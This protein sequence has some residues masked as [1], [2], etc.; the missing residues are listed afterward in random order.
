MKKFFLLVVFLLALS[1]CCEPA[2]VYSWPL[3]PPREPQ[4][5]DVPIIMYH[6]ITKDSKQLG[7]YAI[8]PDEMEADL[9]YLAENDY[10]PVFMADLIR[11]VNGKQSLPKKP[12]VLTFD[13]GRSSDYDYLLPLL[14]KYDMKAVLSIVGQFTDENSEATYKKKPHLTWDQ[15]EEIHKSKRVE[16]QSHSYH[17]HDSIGC[18]RRKGESMEAYQKRLKADLSKFQEMLTNKIGRTPTTFTYPLG[19]ISKGSEEVLKD[20]NFQASLSCSEGINTIATGE[21][22]GLFQLKRNIRRSGQ[23]ISSILKKLEDKAKTK[24]SGLLE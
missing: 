4:T 6:L 18:G 3:F 12:I 14:E 24:K 11:F 1:F 20:L 10:E 15:V 21:P 23:P 7:Q 9:K 2:H 19:V 5:R 17:F 13:D 22:D 8:S 16:I